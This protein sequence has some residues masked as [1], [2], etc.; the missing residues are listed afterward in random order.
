MKTNISIKLSDDQRLNIAQKYNNTTNKKLL[1]RKE[2]N[3][4]VLNFVEE[5]FES[6]GSVRNTTKRIIENGEW[7]K[8]HFYEGKRISKEDYDKMPDGP[9][10]FYGFD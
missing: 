3:D 5:L 2:L 9:R 10:K 4:I 7:T 6:N 1:T 8:I